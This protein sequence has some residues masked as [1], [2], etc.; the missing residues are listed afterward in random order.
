[1]EVRTYSYPGTPGFSSYCTIR[2]PVP[3]WRYLHR[4]RYVRVRVRHSND[5]PCDYVRKKKVKNDATNAHHGSGRKASDGAY[6]DLEENTTA[7]A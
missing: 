3:V 5:L 2:I 6:I 7:L 4:Y 1:M